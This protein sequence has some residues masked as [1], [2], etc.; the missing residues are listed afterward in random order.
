[1][2]RVLMQYSCNGD[3]WDFDVCTNL[4]DIERIVT[5]LYRDC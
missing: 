5:D 2:E 1:M 4:N 3:M